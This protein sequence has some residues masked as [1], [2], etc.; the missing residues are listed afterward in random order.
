MQRWKRKRYVC[1]L[2]RLVREMKHVGKDFWRKKTSHKSQKIKIYVFWTF[3]RLLPNREN[4]TNLGSVESGRCNEF[5]NL[6]KRLNI[7]MKKSLINFTRMQ[8]EERIW[9]SWNTTI[10][11]SLKGLL[12]VFGNGEGFQLN[13]IRVH[14][15]SHGD[16][17]KT[18]Y[19]LLNPWFF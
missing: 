6:Y 15:T 5:G 7:T 4:E 1:G 19:E 8:S 2:A 17:G 16:K 9:S 12:L 18:F 3:E 13:C 10:G 11:K 14:A